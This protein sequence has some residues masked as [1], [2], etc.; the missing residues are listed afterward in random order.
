MQS[1]T[2]A[3]ARVGLSPTRVIALT[4]A[5]ASL[6]RPVILLPWR[7]RYRRTPC[8]HSLT[9]RINKRFQA[10]ESRIAAETEADRTSTAN[11]S[12]RSA[13]S[14]RSNN[15]SSVHHRRCRHRHQIFV[16]V[17][18]VFSRDSS[19]FISRMAGPELIYGCGDLAR[20][21]ASPIWAK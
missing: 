7:W 16:V 18:A 9:D 20:Q 5:I 10:N 11:L 13:H 8:S 14:S 19:K 12:S 15:T 2:A 6:R 3:R 1:A 17:R 21:L 4:L